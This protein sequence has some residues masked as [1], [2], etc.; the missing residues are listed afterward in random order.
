[1]PVIAYSLHANRRTIAVRIVV[2]AVIAVRLCAFRRSPICRRQ[3]RS[4]DR[5][6]HARDFYL[7]TQR[8]PTPTLTILHAELPD[9]QGMRV[10][11]IRRELE[12]YGISTKSFLEKKEMVAALEKVRAEGKT[13]VNGDRAGSSNSSS[14]SGSRTTGNGT[15]TSNMS[16]QTTSFAQS[17]RGRNLGAR[18]R[19]AGFASAPG[20]YP[21][22]E[23][24]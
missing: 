18:R 21:T 3:N 12:S 14:S 1:M 17:W 23:S 5:M 9:L 4:H 8:Q 24:L 13:P 15:T 19:G 10:G 7:Q 16:L 22:Q 2:A 6:Q 20:Q 11:D